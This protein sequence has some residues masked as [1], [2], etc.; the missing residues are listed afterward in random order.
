VIV[1]AHG[2]ILH[3]IAAQLIGDGRAREGLGPGAWLRLDPEHPDARQAEPLS[4]A[5]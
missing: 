4:T 5:P 2:A 1:V 3:A